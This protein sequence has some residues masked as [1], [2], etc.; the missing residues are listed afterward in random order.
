MKHPAV[1]LLT[2]SLFI[3][4]YFNISLTLDVISKDIDISFEREIS[5]SHATQRDTLLKLVPE[6]KPSISIND[7]ESV[8]KSKHPGEPIYVKDSLLQWRLFNFS[9]NEYNNLT[10]IWLGS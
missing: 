10:E 5:E 9:F 2:L 1:L 7:L 8:I 6:I 4:I 3:S